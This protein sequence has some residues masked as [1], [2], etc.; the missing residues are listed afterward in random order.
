L[1]VASLPVLAASRNAIRSE[2]ST[3]ITTERSISRGEEGGV[4]LVRELDRDRDGTLDKRELP[5]D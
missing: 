4:S 5:E 2:C 3:P 1:S